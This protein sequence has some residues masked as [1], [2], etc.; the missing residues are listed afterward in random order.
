MKV[1]KKIGKLSAVL[2]VVLAAGTGCVLADTPE[3]ECVVKRK[4]SSEIQAETVAAGDG[5]TIESQVQAS[6]TYKWNYTENGLEILVHADVKVPK[7][8]GFKLWQAE[9]SFFEQA[10]IEGWLQVLTQGE[11]LWW[12]EESSSSDQFVEQVE[13]EPAMDAQ[14]Y[15]EEWE[16]Q[17]GDY[18]KEPE[19]E[20]GIKEE[21]PLYGMV[22]ITDTFA[23]WAQQEEKSYQISIQRSY[24]ESVTK[25]GFSFVRSDFPNYVTNVAESIRESTGTKVSKKKMRK[26]ADALMEKMELSEE[27]V[28]SEAEAVYN[29]EADYGDYEYS[30]VKNTKGWRFIYS[31]KLEDQAVDHVSGALTSPENV[32]SVM[33]LLYYWGAMDEDTQ[34][35]MN[36]QWEESMTGWGEEEFCITFDDEGLVSVIWKNPCTVKKVSNENV[37]LLPFSEIEQIFEKSIPKQLALEAFSAAGMRVRVDITE[38]RLG[39]MR[40]STLEDSDMAQIIPVWDFIGTVENCSLNDIGLSKEYWMEEHLA[41]SQSISLLT[42]NATDGT[43]VTRKCGSL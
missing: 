34:N 36:A 39:Y 17:D 1:L 43:I 10:E 37:F 42:I 23:P 3:D 19:K 24:G 33:N 31:R 12:N 32:I 38:V 22:N 25:A 6:D 41:L 15:V 11:E 9:P 21:Q 30:T 29:T 8:E 35:E 13:T 20:E 28:F 26:A 14:A 18:D 4:S 40:T 5:L 27:L 16:Y 2:F 7:A